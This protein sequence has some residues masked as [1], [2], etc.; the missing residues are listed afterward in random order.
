[1]GPA[2]TPAFQTQLGEALCVRQVSV[3]YFSG[4]AG[5]GAPTLVCGTVGGRV[6][7]HDPHGGLARAR[8][9]AGARGL[10]LSSSSSS[11][12]ISFLEGPEKPWCVTCGA[13]D[14]G[15]LRDGVY[16][17]SASGLTRWDA[18]T[19]TSRFEAG[20][21]DGANCVVVCGRGVGAQGGP[22]LAVV[23]SNCALYG[24]D[25]AGEEV[26]WT[27]AG[28]DVRS[29][30]S[31]GERDGAGG[32]AAGMLVGTADHDIRAYRDE[33]VVMEVTEADVPIALRDLGGGVFGFG[34]ANGMVGVYEK[35]KR[36][37]RLR[38]DGAAA[39]VVAFDVD[40]DG[41]HEV[42]CG[43]AGG[44]VEV[45]DAQEGHMRGGEVLSAAIAGLIVADYRLAGHAQLCCVTAEGEIRGYAALEGA[46]PRGAAKGGNGAVGSANA[47]A[48][49]GA[50]AGGVL[51]EAAAQ[52]LV[53]KKQSLLQEL[54]AFK[55]HSAQNIVALKTG[56]GTTLPSPKAAI[57]DGRV[58][59]SMASGGRVPN[60]VVG[61]GPGVAVREMVLRSDGL[62]PEK[63]HLRDV[64]QDRG[65][66]GIE[67]PLVPARG[68]S[69]PGF[70]YDVLVGPGLIASSTSF[71]VYRG[72]CTPKKYISY[73]PCDYV[74]VP[75]SGSV[76]F[77]L[78]SDPEAAMSCIRENFDMPGPPRPLASGDNRTLSWVCSTTDKP[79]VLHLQ[80][81]QGGV[82]IIVMTDNLTLAGDV[83]QDVI[84]YLKVED[85]DAHVEFIP[86]FQELES[87]IE[88]VRAQ[89]AEQVNLRSQ[90]VDSTRLIS[91]L[92]MKAEDYRLLDHIALMTT[93]LTD[94]ARLNEDLIREHTIAVE[95]HK[96]LMG[97]L[98]KIN[99]LLQRVSRCRA[100]LPKQDMIAKFRA[101]MKAAGGR[102]L[103]RILSTGK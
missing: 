63:L 94:M 31:L 79:L 60:L 77:V 1:M 19:G 89:G 70:A 8:E 59:S 38:G 37:W 81:V 102:E 40:G 42:A 33:D 43:W 57:S 32:G 99:T 78:R 80:G 53:D 35:E 9:E 96:S 101:A 45:R 15:S 95:N 22:P 84:R 48:R 44:A 4:D 25:A 11:P 17:G 46:A 2:L 55:V 20:V 5:G 103:V 24:F 98:R 100:G 26:L 65:P 72:L 69:V 52:A 27:V 58:M 76:Q 7:L 29:V 47:G 88:I 61:H 56:S 82:Q 30:A 3:G 12:E 39:D 21:Q 49:A 93:S 10:A 62:F 34:L 75:P 73:A 83:V 90:T 14:M 16:V 18:A 67:V 85:L 23:G 64:A 87:V 92:V 91:S 71:H 86:E 36:R 51:D 74:P 66:S 97:G 50:G 41:V 6:L 28:D 54:H 68:A 13:L